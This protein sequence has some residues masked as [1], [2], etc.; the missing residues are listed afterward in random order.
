MES[1]EGLLE[2]LQRLVDSKAN[3]AVKL[4]YL[5][6][7]ELDEIDQMDLGAVTEFKRSGNGSV[8]I[9]FVDRVAALRWLMERSGEEKT[10]ERFFQWL[11]E[12]SGDKGGPE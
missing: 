10:G 5:S 4:A 6:Q 2:Q 1:R 3:D 9:K 12:H 11:E 8:E 7:E